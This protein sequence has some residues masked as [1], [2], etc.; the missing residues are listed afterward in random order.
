MPEVVMKDGRALEVD[1]EELA[2]F[3][4]AHAEDILKEKGTGEPVPDVTQFPFNLS[5]TGSR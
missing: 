5:S 1:I 4:E 3:M 2:E